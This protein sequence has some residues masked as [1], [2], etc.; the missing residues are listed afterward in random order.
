LF[1]QSA[2]VWFSSPSYFAITFAAAPLGR[3]F[4]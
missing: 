2:R 1:V 4:T 3:S